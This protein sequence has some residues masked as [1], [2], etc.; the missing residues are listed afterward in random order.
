MLDTI[1]VTIEPWPP[2]NSHDG[3]VTHWA[4]CLDSGALLLFGSK[5]E[6]VAK[7]RQIGFT[8]TNH[9]DVDE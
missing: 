7:A 6:A 1:P 5:R 9:A 8:I 4:I 3:R 2:R